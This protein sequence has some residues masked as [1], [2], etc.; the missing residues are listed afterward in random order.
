MLILAV[1]TLHILSAVLFLGAGLMSAYYKTRADRCGDLRVVAWYQ[2]EIVRADW[3]FTVPTG[4]LLPLT[5]GWLVLKYELPWSTSWVQWGL[6]GYV[7]TTLLWAPAAWLQIRMRALAS[8]A[9]NLG[10]ELSAEFHRMNRVWFL[11]GLPAFV[12]AIFT[13]WVMVTKATY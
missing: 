1:K 7:V 10:I 6:G 12:V 5:G 8:D 3:L 11:L 13:M 4:V 9:L 2:K